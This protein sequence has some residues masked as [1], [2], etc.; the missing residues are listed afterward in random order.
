MVKDDIYK[1]TINEKHL[2][3]KK[4]GI[5]VLMIIVAIGLIMIAKNSIEVIKQHKVY[6]Q[7]EGQLAAL[8][9][10]KE[11]KQIQ[12]EE[13][14]QEKQAKIPKVTQEGKDNLQNIYQAETKRAFLTFDDGPSIVTPTILDILKQEDVKATFFVLGAGVN[15]MPET[16][17]RI[18]EEGHYIAN[19][20]YSHS[21]S[22]IYSSPQTVLDEFNQCNEAVRKAIGVP[23]YHSHLFRFPGGLLGGKYAELK[24]QANEL[25]LQNDI[26]HVDW[27]ALTGDAETANPT[28]EF[29]MQRLEETVTNKSSVVILMHD[30]QAKK[31]TAEALPQIIS[32]LRENGYE[33]KNFYE[34]MK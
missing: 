32:W 22:A 25:L 17:K 4:V 1:I 34:I 21:Y 9:K 10:Q 23:E 33:F 30:A 31:V 6:E 29:E 8:D 26:L 14:K 12:N 11:D 3:T 7:Y 18:Y 28:I 20:G 27:N 13:N 19:H 15:A 24:R 5:L 2:N 16:T